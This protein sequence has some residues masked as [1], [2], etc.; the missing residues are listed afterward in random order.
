MQTNEE[1]EKIDQI[2]CRIL[3]DRQWRRQDESAVGDTIDLS[4]DVSEPPHHAVSV[5]SAV[6]EQRHLDAVAAFIKGY[7]IRSL[8]GVT[9]RVQPK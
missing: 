8:A 5:D 4:L 6:V 9:L 1:Q 2:L 3:V 7:P